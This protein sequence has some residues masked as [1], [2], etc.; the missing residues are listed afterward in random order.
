MLQMGIS[1]R[2]YFPDEGNQE[3]NFVL[4]NPGSAG[5]PRVPAGMTS[6]PGVSP[7]PCTAFPSGAGVAGTGFAGIVGP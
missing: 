6:S 1:P 5:V 7:C 4:L 3:R 2:F